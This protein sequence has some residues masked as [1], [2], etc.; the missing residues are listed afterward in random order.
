MVYKQVGY[1]LIWMPGKCHS[2]PMK[3]LLWQLKEKQEIYLSKYVKL[4]SVLF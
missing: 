4:G 3:L 1:D 2:M